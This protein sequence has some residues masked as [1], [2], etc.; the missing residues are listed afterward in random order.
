[1]KI[2]DTKKSSGLWK[3]MIFIVACL[4]AFTNMASISS[5]RTS[6]SHVGLQVELDRGVLPTDNPQNVVIKVTLDAPNPPQDTE[7]PPVNLAIILDRS[8]SM[9]GQKLEKAKEAAIEALHRLSP[10]DI[11]SLIVYDTNVDTIVPAQKATNIHWIESR[12]KGIHTGGNTALFGG[13]S[14]GA[15]EIRKNLGDRYVNRIILLSDGLANIGPQTPEDLGR[16]GAALI[17]EEISVTT[18]GVGMDYNEDLMARLSQNSDGNTYFVESSVDLPRIFAAELGDVLNVVA[19]KVN[20]TIEC[21]DGVKP[22][23]IIGRE[24][25][26]KGNTVELS[27]NQLYGGQDKYALVEV[28]IP[29]GKNGESIEVARARVTYDNPFTKQR[30][31]SDGRAHAMYSKDESEVERAVNVKVKRELHLNKKALAEEKAITYYDQGK[32]SEAIGALKGSA[33]EMRDYGLKYKD[34]D[35]LEQAAEMEIEA[36]KIEKEGMSK[37]S[38]KMMRTKSYQYKNQQ[39]DPSSSIRR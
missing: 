38:R 15:A 32:R 18:V 30:E 1:M 37:K 8:G 29:S 16:L 34:Q 33:Q 6:K 17:K 4:F 5:A 22:V 39:S 36:T 23:R 25:R 35:I 24:G 12:I 13:V 27:I 14:Q 10:Q 28:T 20:I 7:R 19:K 2:K 11:F 21:P 31:T 26:I 3:I 9:S